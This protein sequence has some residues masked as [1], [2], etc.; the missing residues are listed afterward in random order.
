MIPTIENRIEE[1]TEEPGTYVQRLIANAG[2]I[3]DAARI[4][5]IID[6]DLYHIDLRR[7]PFAGNPELKKQARAAITAMAELRDTLIN[8]AWKDPEA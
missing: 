2:S 5:L 6:G 8:F 3:E 4:D 7:R 1:L